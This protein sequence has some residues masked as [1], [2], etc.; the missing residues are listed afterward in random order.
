MALRG[1]W[2]HMAEFPNNI[3]GV[4]IKERD[5]GNSKTCAT[6]L[7]LGRGPFDLFVRGLLACW[8][9]GSNRS[10][11]CMYIAAGSELSPRSMPSSRCHEITKIARMRIEVVDVVT[12]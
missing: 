4:D 3:H 8:T 7:N 2:C 1:R 11:P 10:T 6:S 9:T 12:W 5:T